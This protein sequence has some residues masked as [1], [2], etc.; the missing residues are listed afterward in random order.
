[1]F[2]A[3]KNKKLGTFK[4]DHM[5]F[6]DA[7]ARYLLKLGDFDKAMDEFALAE[8]IFDEVG[9]KSAMARLDHD[10]AKLLKKMNRMDDARERLTKAL[11]H[12]EN[13]GAQVRAGRVRAEL[14]N[15]G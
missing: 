1:M 11:A 7:D 14:E 3:W 13:I 10:L 4:E 15:L 5:W 9:D 6:H 12:Y 8:A 2:T